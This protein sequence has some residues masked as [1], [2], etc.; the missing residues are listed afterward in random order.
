FVLRTFE[1]RKVLRVPNQ[2]EIAAVAQR[3]PGTLVMPLCRKNA[4]LSCEPQD[5]ESFRYAAVNMG[6]TGFDE[7]QAS[8]RAALAALPFEFAGKTL[9]SDYRLS[10]SPA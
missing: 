4:W 6:S 2:S 10:E 5:R 7:L 9:R 8:F 1:D 3:F